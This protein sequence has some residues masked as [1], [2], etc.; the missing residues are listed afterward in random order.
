MD[1]L[2]F[3]LMFCGCI[4]CWFLVTVSDGQKCLVAG[5]SGEPLR[6]WDKVENGKTRK[7]ENKA[8]ERRALDTLDVDFSDLTWLAF[9]LARTGMWGC[10]DVGLDRLRHDKYD[11]TLCQAMS[12]ISA[13]PTRII[14]YSTMKLQSWQILIVEASVI[15]AFCGSLF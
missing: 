8:Q 7:R 9:V 13:E 15:V 5:S 14:T 11:V 12:V 10:E 3:V 6:K 1:V 2:W 4:F